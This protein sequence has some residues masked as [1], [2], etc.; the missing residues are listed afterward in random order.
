MGF[1]CSHISIVAWRRWKNDESKKNE[2]GGET[3]SFR[4]AFCIKNSFP[5]AALS[6]S[7]THNAQVHWNHF[8]MQ[9]GNFMSLPRK[10]MK[11][12]ICGLYVCVSV[13]V[14]VCLYL[15]VCKLRLM[16]HQ[17]S[18]IMRNRE[19]QNMIKTH[20]CTS[21]NINFPFSPIKLLKFRHLIL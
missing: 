1:M 10:F 2:M 21:T 19:D 15:S 3:K 9:R 5:P 18:R 20:V 7:K 11:H 14:C 13:C 8:E 17:H 6:I 16:N 12:K 4:V